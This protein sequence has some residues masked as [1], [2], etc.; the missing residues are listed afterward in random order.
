MAVR[1]IARLFAVL[2]LAWAGQAFSIGGGT[3]WKP[4]PD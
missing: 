2:S 3:T 4:I 1:I